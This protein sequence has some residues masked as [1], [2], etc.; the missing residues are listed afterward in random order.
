MLH[1]VRVS[2][3]DSCIMASTL[4][5]LAF[6]GP[7]SNCEYWTCGGR[8]RFGEKTS[9]F[10]FQTVVDPRKSTLLRSSPRSQTILWNPLIILT[11][12]LRASS[13]QHLSEGVEAATSLAV[14]SRYVSELYSG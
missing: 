1:G 4:E 14:E 11:P 2:G 13:E 6:I 7:A 3:F 9:L 8:C 10:S 5:S 12:S